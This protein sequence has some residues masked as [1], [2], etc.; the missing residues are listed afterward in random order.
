MLKEY[1]VEIRVKDWI[2]VPKGVS[3]TIVYEEVLAADEFFARRIGFDQ[4]ANRVKYEPVTRR[5][6]AQRNLT[7]VDCCAPDSVEI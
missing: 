7:L 1:L 4:F 6:M 3:R 2:H 5:I